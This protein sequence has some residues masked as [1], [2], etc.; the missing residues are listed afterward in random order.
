VVV[1]I[2]L[3][4]TARAFVIPAVGQVHDNSRTPVPLLGMTV[5]PTIY[6]GSDIGVRI[7]GSRTTGPTGRIVGAYQRGMAGSALL[8]PTTTLWRESRRARL[9]RLV[10]GFNALHDLENFG[11]AAR[12]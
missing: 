4:F 11:G 8:K 6:S 3:G 12:I 5:L 7:S 9:T 1:G 2:I 10:N